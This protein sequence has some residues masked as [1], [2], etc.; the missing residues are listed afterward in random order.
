MFFWC[1]VWVY[2]KSL[3]GSPA[4]GPDL[5]HAIPLGWSMCEVPFRT[6]TKEKWKCLRQKWQ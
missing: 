1:A 5:G 3:N 6:A 4:A 2:L